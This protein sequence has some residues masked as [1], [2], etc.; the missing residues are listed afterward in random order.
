M[1]KTFHKLFQVIDY[2]KQYQQ[3]SSGLNYLQLHTLEKIYKQKAMK[4]LEISKIME[5]S[6]STLIGVLDE[7]EKKNL[8]TRERQKEDKRIVVVAPTELGEQIVENHFKEDKAFLEN[9][10]KSLNADE[11]TKL[12]ELLEKMTSGIQDLDALFQYE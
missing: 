12:V 7:L 5:I 4:T 6:P 8:I 11:Q 2:K 1:Q 10:L 3:K 9:L